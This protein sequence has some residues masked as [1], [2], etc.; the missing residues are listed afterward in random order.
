MDIKSTQG[1]QY[2]NFRYLH[3]QNVNIKFKKAKLC[4]QFKSIRLPIQ[5]F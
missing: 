5:K 3:N 1:F 4:I 2:W